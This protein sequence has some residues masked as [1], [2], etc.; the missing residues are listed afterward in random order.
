MP[1]Q[2]SAADAAVYER[3]AAVSGNRPVSDDDYADLVAAMDTLGMSP[4]LVAAVMDSKN[5]DATFSRCVERAMQSY[6]RVTGM[7]AHAVVDLS[8]PLGFRV[9]AAAS[10]NAATPRGQHKTGGWSSSRNVFATP[11]EFN[12]SA[13]SPLMHFDAP[14]PI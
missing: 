14:S 7:N 6:N 12:A 9:I 4:E 11:P 3:I 1:R 5:F 13:F 2:W 10:A 8:Q